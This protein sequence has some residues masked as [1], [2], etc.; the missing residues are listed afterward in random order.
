[1][2]ALVDNC[3]GPTSVVL[4]VRDDV[5]WQIDSLAAANAGPEVVDETSPLPAAGIAE[6]VIGQAPPDWTT[7]TPLS[8]PL[9]PEIRYTV[10]TEP[11]GQTIDFATPDLAGGLL[12]D[13]LGNS[14]FNSDLMSV[15]CSQPADIGAFTRNIF[16]L[17]LLGAVSVALVLVA[18][19]SLLFIVTRRFSRVRSIQRR[20]Q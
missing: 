14:R 13:G 6:F 12:W 8:E 16:V 1:V 9:T 2:R 11:D 4:S 10:R 7:V 19:I 3:P 15:E 20:P 5:L 18:I 17:G